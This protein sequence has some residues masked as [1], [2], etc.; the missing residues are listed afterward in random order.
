MKTKVYI[1]ILIHLVVLNDNSAQNNPV[2][3][4]FSGQIIGWTNLNFGDE[5]TSQSG[6]RYIPELSSEYL[7]NKTWKLDAEAS[8]NIYGVGTYAAD[9]WDSDRKIKPYRLWLR[10]SSDRFIVRGGLQKINFGSASLLRPLMWF[11]QIDPRYPLQL[12][13]G[14]YGL[15]TKYYFLNNANIWFWVLY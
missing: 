1:I 13:D 8:A 4:G 15:L 10:L 7:I 9:Q 12:T 3:A 5:F 2:S 14:V 11:D 6:L